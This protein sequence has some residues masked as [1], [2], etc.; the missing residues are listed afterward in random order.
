[1]SEPSKNRFENS[2]RLVLGVLY[3]M[4]GLAMLVGSFFLVKAVR[5]EAKRGV[6]RYIVL[7]ERRPDS[8]IPQTPSKDLVAI[9][10]GLQRKPYTFRADA[11]GYIMPSQ[12]HQKPDLTVVFLGGSTTECMYMQEEE[13]FPYLVGRTMEKTMGLKV[14]TINAGNAGNNSL[15]SLLVLQ[16]KVLPQ[17]PQ[18]IVFMECINDLNFLM[19]VGDYWT[20]SASR[21]IVYDRDYGPVKRFI[22][23]Y[24]AGRAPQEANHEEDLADMSGKEQGIDTVSITAAYRKNLEHFI[25]LC[26]Q[27]NVVPV[28]MTQF[29]RY[30]D[31]PKE[32]LLRQMRGWN[33]QYKSWHQ[34]FMAMQ[35]TLRTVAEEQ[36][37][38][39][40]DLDVL[41]PKDKKYMYDGV[42]LNANGSALVAG[43][44]AERLPE[45]LRRDGGSR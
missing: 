2:P 20:P 24:L 35:N 38:A 8:D 36:K 42:H 6:E 21:G 11:D 5:D 3:S 19:T 44:V 12:V 15:H 41:V 33:K 23:K 29:N 10:D 27:H 13:R 45:I 25:F 26:R 43:L 30:S 17:K 28:L 22:L 9:A 39:F 34:A 37:V 16:A 32:N 31:T 40:I 1:M 7:R 4:L 14:N 18:A